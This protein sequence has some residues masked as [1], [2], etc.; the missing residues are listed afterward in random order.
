MFHDGEIVQG[1]KFKEKDNQN[2]SELRQHSEKNEDM[3]K[4]ISWLGD[5]SNDKYMES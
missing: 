1:R 4:I 2:I 3:K 5:T